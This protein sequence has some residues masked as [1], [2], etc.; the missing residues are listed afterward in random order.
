METKIIKISELK[1]NPR[2]AKAHAVNEIK[3]SIAEM[4]VIEHIVVDENDMILAGHGR[5]LALQQLSKDETEVVVKRG[6]SQEQKDRYLLMSNKLTELGGWD[7]DTLVNFSE[8][9]LLNAHWKSEELDKIFNLDSEE[10]DFQLEEELEKITEPKVK[11]GDLFILGGEV[12]C[13][14]CEKIHRL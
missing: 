3:S 2:N 13:P 9:E 8:E 6:L 4:D 1:L 11:L 5:L 14:K 12:K 10:D 7:L